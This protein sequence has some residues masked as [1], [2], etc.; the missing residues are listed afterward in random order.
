MRGKGI[1]LYENY[2][3]A[4]TYR[5]GSNSNDSAS[6]A[7]PSRLTFISVTYISSIFYPESRVN[8]VPGPALSPSLPRLVA[9]I[10]LRNSRTRA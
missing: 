4:K 8:S 1:A 7:K 10:V 6:P 3:R 5:L 9:L 2:T